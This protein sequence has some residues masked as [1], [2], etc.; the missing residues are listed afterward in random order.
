MIKELDTIVLSHGI[1]EHGL[2]KGDVG[3]VVHVY[4]GGKTIEAEFI[5][6]D[7]K[8]VALLTLDTTDIRPMAKNELLHV[9]DISSTY[10]IS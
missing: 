8:T 4:K 2:K 10:S 1:K 6:A 7:G 3:A 5:K 9:R